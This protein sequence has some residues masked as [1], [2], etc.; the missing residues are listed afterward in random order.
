MLVDENIPRD[1]EEWL[2]KKG[3]ETVNISKL[4]LRGAKDICFSGV[5]RKKQNG[6]YHIRQRFC[7]TLPHVSKRH[8]NH[9]NNSEN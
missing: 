9:G 4:Q 3:F 7:S 2:S 8:P 5:R 6:N 1:V